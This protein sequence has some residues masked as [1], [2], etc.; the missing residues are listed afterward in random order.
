LSDVHDVVLI[1]QNS[2]L[3]VIHIQVV[4]GAEYGH[5]TR[6]SCSPS[7]A[8]HTIS[9]I[10]GFVG[11][12]NRQEIVLLKERARCRVREKIR[13]PSHVIVNKEVIS[14]LLAEFLQR[15]SPKNVAH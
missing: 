14:L 10:L 15:I 12:N 3:I 5:N 4:G 6:E 7:F 8:V 11:T 13:A 9:G 1:L 2:S